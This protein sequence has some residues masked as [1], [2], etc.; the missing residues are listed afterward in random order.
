[1]QELYKLCEQIN[2][3][4]LQCP[5]LELNELQGILSS[6]KYTLLTAHVQSFEKKLLEL[7]QKGVGSILDLVQSLG[8]LMVEPSH[9][10]PPVVHKSSI[11]GKYFGRMTYICSCYSY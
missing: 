4:Y 11:I 2:F 8:R 7:H 9:M 6:G 10:V 3:K 1:L 5:D